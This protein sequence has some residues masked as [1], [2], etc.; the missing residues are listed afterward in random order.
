MA[1]R[2]GKGITTRLAWNISRY[3][4]GISQDRI[5]EM[6]RKRREKRKDV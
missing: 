1:C 4:F 2:K 6:T 3:N 5:K